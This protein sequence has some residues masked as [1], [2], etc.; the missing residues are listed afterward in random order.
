VDLDDAEHVLEVYRRTEASFGST[1]VLGLEVTGGELLEP[2]AA[3]ARRIEIVGDSI[4][5]GYGN[6]G[7]IPTCPFSADTENHYASYGALLARELDAELSTV[8]WSG[9]G[10]VS[11]YGGDKTDPLPVLYDRAVPTDARSRWRFGWQPDAVIVNLG[12][13]DYS[14]N[15]DPS[16]AEFVATYQSLLAR[17]REHYPNAFIL[18]TVGPLLGGTDLATAR[19]NIAAAVLARNAA[20]DARVKAHALTTGNANPGCDYHPGLAT[21]VAMATELTTALRSELGW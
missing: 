6:E 8:A 7:T 1:V 21:H 16:D 2:P 19:A 3:P 20:G 17:L 5:C 14:T 10:V 13:N 18:C 11:N 12:T 4:T 9:K 15:S